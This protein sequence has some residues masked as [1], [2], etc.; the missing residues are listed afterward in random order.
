ML[1]HL[2][3]IYFAIRLNMKAIFHRR[4]WEEQ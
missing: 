1:M 3:L 4:P 2:I